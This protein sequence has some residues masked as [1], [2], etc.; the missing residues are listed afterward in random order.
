MIF[1]VSQSLRRS[2]NDRLTGMDTQRVEVFHVTYGDTVVETVAHHFVFHFLPAFQTLFHQH[3]RRERESFLGQ[4]VQFFFVVAETRAQTSQCVCGTDDDRI[5]QFL[6]GTACILD[7]LYRFTL[8]CLHIDFIQLL[9]EKLTVFRIHDGLYRCTQHA[10]IIF[11]EDTCL[12]QS[13]TTV[14]CRLSTER[15][16]HTVR[17]FLGNHLFYE[18]R[19]HRKEIDLVGNPIRGL[20][21]RDVRVDEDSFDTFFL[22]RLQG[23]RT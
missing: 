13:H 3:L 17:T 20:H 14:Q 16:E 6:G 5:T 22:Q 9:H 15:Q 10:C 8:D 21:G 4:Y 7:I 23:L 11:F 1:A 18:I 19:S 2:D 12:I